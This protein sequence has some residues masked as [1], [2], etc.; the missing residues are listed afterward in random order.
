MWD[1]LGISWSWILVTF[2]GNLSTSCHPFNLNPPASGTYSLVQGILFMSHV[3]F[4][5][6]S[7][8]YF[9]AMTLHWGQGTTNATQV[10][11]GV[12]LTGEAH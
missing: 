12:M 2:Q 8:V 11:L 9:Y 4:S 10:T 3:L 1:A 7:S 6:I 5:F